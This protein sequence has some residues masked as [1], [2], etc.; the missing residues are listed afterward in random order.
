MNLEDIAQLAGVS[1]STVSRV[2]NNDPRVSSV[3][4]TRVLRIIAEHNYH[5]NSAARSLASRQSRIFG[6]LI[7]Q[8]IYSIFGDPWFPPM[9]EGCMTAC[10]T[11]DYSLMLF[12]ES[13]NDLPSVERLIE[14]TVHTR[15]IDGLVISASLE[16]DILSD[17]LAAEQF[18][19]IVIGRDT[20]QRF[21]FVDIDNR[22]A[23]R[24]ATEHLLSHGYRH[25]AA[26][27]GPRSMVTAEDRLLGFFDALTDASLD[28]TSAPVR[29]GNYQER[30]AYCQAIEL[31]TSASPPE[32]IFVASDSMAWGVLTAARSLHL[33]IPGDLAVIGFDGIQLERNDREGLS[34]I[35]QP[36][37]QLGSRAVELLICLVAHHQ[38]SPVQEWLPVELVL[39]TSCGCPVPNSM[40]STPSVASHPSQAMIGQVAAP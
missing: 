28:P 38:H 34:S 9:I 18:P 14:R 3:V 13:S 40:Q 5:P 16:N 23:A 19:S 26:I 36:A 6:L 22:G 7:P 15:H 8:A 27:V 25:V 11:A 37:Q 20:E 21:S 31:L 39:N 1:R 33:R 30:E 24:L 12:M 32:A 4:R 29:F 2:V 35:R 10:R 17:R